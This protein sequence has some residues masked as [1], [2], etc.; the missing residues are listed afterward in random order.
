MK[1]RYF[2]IIL[3]CAAWSMLFLAGCGGGKE[4]DGKGDVIAEEPAGKTETK[5]P[6]AEE[7]ELEELAVNAE[8]FYGCWE[9]AS[10]YG[11]LYIYGDGTLEWVDEDGYGEIY[12]YYIEDGEL[13]IEGSDLRYTIDGEGGMYDNDGDNLF[14]SEEPGSGATYVEEHGI[15]INYELGQGDVIVDDAAFYYERGTEGAG[16]TTGPLQVSIDLEYENETDWQF[17]DEY[18]IERSITAYFGVPEEY[19]PEFAN[20]IAAGCKYMFYDAYSGTFLPDAPYF[21]GGNG[22]G[23]YYFEFET[24]QGWVDLYV[25]QTHD[26][27]E[28]IDGYAIVFSVEMTIVAPPWYEGLVLTVPVQPDTYEERLEYVDYTENMDTFIS[29]DSQPYDIENGLNCLLLF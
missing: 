28:D 23:S 9:Y 21:E 22:E 18:Y 24:D 17:E 12:N 2:S 14:L 6:A 29:I 15:D 25:D 1:K 20:G 16:F 19:A 8:D 27:R 7:P 5:E 3:A 4:D 11:F 13:C 26:M 10:G